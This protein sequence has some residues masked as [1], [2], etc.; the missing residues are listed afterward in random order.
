MCQDVYGD[1]LFITQ[2]EEGAVEMKLSKWEREGKSDSTKTPETPATIHSISVGG[3]ERKERVRIGN[4][5]GNE[6]F[7][8]AIGTGRRVSDSQVSQKK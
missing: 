3:N 6:R 7:R 4:D 8:G 2:K 5:A 1:L